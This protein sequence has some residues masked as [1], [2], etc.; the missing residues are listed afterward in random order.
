MLLEPRTASIFYIQV[1]DSINKPCEDESRVL[2]TTLWLVDFVFG[3]A[4]NQSEYIIG[5]LPSIP[6]NLSFSDNCCGRCFDLQQIVMQLSAQDLKDSC[7]AKFLHTR[8]HTSFYMVVYEVDFSFSG[9]CWIMSRLT[10]C[11]TLKEQI[12][13]TFRMVLV[14]R[15]FSHPQR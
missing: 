6:Q 7:T 12:N 1:Q 14:W 13:K 9:M 15:P 2:S 8:L 4:F 3:C 10:S 11:N 5:L